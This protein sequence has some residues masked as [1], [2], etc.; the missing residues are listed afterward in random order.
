MK[1]HNEAH[2]LPMHFVIGVLSVCA[3]GGTDHQSYISAVGD[4][5]VRR[6]GLR[7][8]LEAWNFCNEVGLEDPSVELPTALIS[9]ELQ[10]HL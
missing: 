1:N 10:R 7:V 6:D 3:C 4:P 8:A 2:G 9:Q 5:G